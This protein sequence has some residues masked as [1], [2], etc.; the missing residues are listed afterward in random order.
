MCSAP[1]KQKMTFECVMSEQ[2]GT[3]EITAENEFFS[4]DVFNEN[5][6][7]EILDGLADQEGK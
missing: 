1:G 4:E 2:D 6:L 5:L 3:I 7:E